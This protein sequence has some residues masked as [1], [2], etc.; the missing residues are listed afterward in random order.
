MVREYFYPAIVLTAVDFGWP[1]V[2][3]CNIHPPEFWFDFLVFCVVGATSSKQ[4]RFWWKTQRQAREDEA[5]L[6]RKK[7]QSPNSKGKGKGKVSAPTTPSSKGKGKQSPASTP[8]SKVLVS[9]PA[10]L[11]SKKTSKVNYL[12]VDSTHWT[13]GACGF[14]RQKS[15]K[16]YV[17]FLLWILLT[18]Y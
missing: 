1:F 6:Q 18:R 9:P 8:K 3:A 12:H 10:A 13:L 2:T 5:A 11:P 7:K 4:L 17:V 15:S 16:G 14:T